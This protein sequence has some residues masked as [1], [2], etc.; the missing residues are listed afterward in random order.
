[1]V[2]SAASGFLAGGF[3]SEKK[4]GDYEKFGPLAL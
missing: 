2:S 1:V 4:I 3:G